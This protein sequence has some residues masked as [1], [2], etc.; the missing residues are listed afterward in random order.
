MDGI[1][2]SDNTY[3]EIISHVRGKA[4]G[5]LSSV[6]TPVSDTAIFK[7]GA[8][9]TA[10]T[11]ASMTSVTATWCYWGGSGVS[12]GT[13]GWTIYSPHDD[14]IDSGTYCICINVYDVWIIVQPINFCPA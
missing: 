7:L 11:P 12:D 9:T 2:L 5:G 13:S 3:N 14:V 10:G 8:D 6:E 4:S 1:V